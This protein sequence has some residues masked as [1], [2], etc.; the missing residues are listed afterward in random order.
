MRDLA[1]VLFLIALLGLGLKRGFLFVLAYIYVDTVSPQR[2]SYYLLNSIPLSLILAALSVAWWALAERKDDMRISGRQFLILLLLAYCG[3]TTL[4]ADFPAEA[5]VKWD[6]VWKALAFAIFL[7]FTMRTRLKIEA[8]LLFLILSA[9]SIIIVGGIKT[10]LSGGGYGMLN[11]MVDNNSGLYESSFIATVAIAII[12]VILW[13]TKYGTIYPPD[14]RVK[15]FCA[16]L[17]LACL[18]IPIGTQARTGL[19][20]IGVLAVLMLRTLKRRVLYI[21]ALALVAVAS[22]PLL[23]SSYTERMQSIQGYQADSSASTR[24]AVWG[25]TLDFVQER[26]F[27]GGFGA[28]LQNRI[29]VSLTSERSVGAVETVSSSTHSDAARAWH[30]SYFEMLGEQGWPGLFLF[31][32]IQIISL[33][34]MEQIRRRYLKDVDLMWASS[35]ATAL[36]GFQIIY[37]VGTLFVQAGFQPFG[38][39]FLSVQIGLGQWLA[40]REGRGRRPG[41]TGHSNMSSVAPVNA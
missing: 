28:Y 18:L 39:M 34:R 2:L 27:G 3:C 25:W 37:L 23:P 19:I 26:P 21:A 10:A 4:Y 20:C 29:Q 33:I 9:A 24:I 17:V 15:L 30:S 5:V 1:L 13:F 35:L 12:P 6:W 16:G 41:W 31:L 8:I 22:V 11:L 38:W 36:Q 32:L 7:P 40:R 14:W